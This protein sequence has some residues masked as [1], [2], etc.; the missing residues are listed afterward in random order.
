VSSVSWHPF[1]SLIVS[2]SIHLSDSIKLWD[3]NS[4]ELVHESK[5]HSSIVSKVAFHPEGNTYFS[6]G[7]DN[8]IA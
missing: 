7:K 3:P 1:K 8:A 2:S 4:E 5:L 6:L